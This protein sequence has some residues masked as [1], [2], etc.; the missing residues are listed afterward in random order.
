MLRATGGVGRRHRQVQALE[1]F[2][3]TFPILSRSRL[4]LSLVTAATLYIAY[5]TLTLPG[6]NQ[7]AGLLI[8]TRNVTVG[9]AVP[10]ALGAP[11]ALADAGFLCTRYAQT[12]SALLS[13]MGCTAQLVFGCGVPGGAAATGALDAF[14][15]HSCVC[16][17]P[18]Y[19]DISSDRVAEK[20]WE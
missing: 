17:A 6:K 18:Y 4:I 16:Q 14:A 15:G 8:F 12:C 20:L 7:T 13:A 9:T 19:F 3:C 1:W 2:A 10:P 5:P 11:P